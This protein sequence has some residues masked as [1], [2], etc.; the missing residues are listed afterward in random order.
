M[1]G[2]DEKF[3]RQILAFGKEGQ[4]KISSTKVGIVGLGGIGAAVAQMLAYLGIG[5]FIQIDDDKVDESNLN[6]LIGAT[7]EDVYRN[8][9]KVDV[10][11]RTIKTVTPAAR[12]KSYNV[13][14]RTEE[15][16]DALSTGP[17]IIFGCVDNDSSR[18]ILTEL[19]AAYRKVLIDCATEIDRKIPEFGGR[20]VVSQPGDF[21]LLCAH[22]I[23]LP[24]A[25]E[26]LES[27]RELRFREEHGY[28]L[29]KQAL[30]PAVISLNAIIAGLAVTEF[31]MLI[32]GM[33]EPNRMVT[34]K[35][36][37][38]VFRESLD[39]KLSNCIICDGAVGKRELVDIKRFLKKEL[40]NDLPK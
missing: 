40:P 12:I 38:G 8:T 18:L 37:R 3:S 34:Y 10:S 20:V 23:D 5:D 6:R 29:G 15:A 31:I 17:D 13:N 36:M 2:N 9:S 26:E 1:D 28:G 39:Q 33:R 35:G 14:L 4:H 27:S 32:T 30:A 22:Q 16:I 21:C 25:H 7:I 11:E 24:I 19:A